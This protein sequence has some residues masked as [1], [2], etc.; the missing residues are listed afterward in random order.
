MKD[1]FYKSLNPHG[2][3]FLWS[4]RTLTQQPFDGYYHWHWG[5]E[6][7]LVHR[8]SGVV[9]VNQKT[10]ELRPGMLFYFLPYQLHKVYAEIDEDNPYERSVIHFDPAYMESYM[11]PFPTL[12]DVFTRMRKGF[13]FEQGLDLAA[14]QPETESVAAAFQSGVQEAG[15]S[16]EG[17][18]A[19]LF[20][21]QLLSVIQRETMGANQERRMKPIRQSE[22]IMAWIERHYREPFQLDKLAGELHMSGSYL[23]RL[24]RQETGSSITGYLAARR[25]QQACSLLQSSNQSVERIGEQVGLP[26]ASYFIQLFK[27]IMGISPHQYRLKL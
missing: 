19:A 15:V 2:K 7:L 25:I 27:R 23:S 13:M 26:N 8:G 22:Q 4:H 11:G 10:Y 16:G 12:K 21:L 24:F 17:E 5:F 18:H 14:M 6:M 3:P 1:L 20:L 9:I